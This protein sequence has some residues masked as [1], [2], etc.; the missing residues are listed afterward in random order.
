MRSAA[1]CLSER[2]LL[3]LA[4]RPLLAYRA[5][6]LIEEEAPVI[7]PSQV[8]SPRGRLKNPGRWYMD[9]NGWWSIRE[10]DWVD[11]DTKTESQA[12]GCRWNGDPNDPA[13]KG[14]PISTGHPTWF[15]LPEPFHAMARALLDAAGQDEAG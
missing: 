6:Q 1:A 8:V 3:D 5:C 10:F 7:H 4:D 2:L 11:D 15:V 13:S 14:N 12:I 9:P